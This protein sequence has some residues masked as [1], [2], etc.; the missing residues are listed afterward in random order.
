MRIAVFSTKPYDRRY[1]DAANDAVG[2]PH[3]MTYLEPRLAADTARFAEGCD[4][5]CVFVND[6][7]DRPALEALQQAGVRWV[8]TRSAGYNHIDLEAAKDLG[9]G[10]ARVPAYAPEGVAE[11]AIAL[12][13]ALNRKI[14]R[15]YNRVRE[16]NFS[17][18]GLIG[19]QMHGRTVGVVGTGKIGAAAARVL[20]GFGCQLLGHDVQESDELKQLGMRYVDLPEL[21]RDSDIITL[22]APLTPET[23]HLINADSLQHIRDGAMLIN[24]GRGGLVDT[25]ALVDALKSGKLGSL[26]LDVYEEE[27]EFFFEDLS[28]SILQDDTFARLLTFPNVII[29]GH[30]AFFTEQAVEQI[31]GETID[32]FNRFAQGDDDTPKAL[33]PFQA[34]HATPST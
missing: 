3:E 17:L 23:H 2:S 29:T 10:V 12:M 19:F 33:T 4:T 20:H 28:T 25:T 6:D 34:S 27:D 30:Q 11:H 8:A 7:A 9:L 16:H 22:H 26:G 31:A 14:H 18:E 32:N 21:L 15:A 5:A 1:L 13:L 24:T